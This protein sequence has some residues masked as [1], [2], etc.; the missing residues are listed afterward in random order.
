[1]IPTGKECEGDVLTIICPR[2]TYRGTVAWMNQECVC[3]HDVR[4]VPSNDDRNTRVPEIV[5]STA[6][7]EAFI[8]HKE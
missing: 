6:A 1:M 2:N 5:I 8:L 4:I 7:I 3:L